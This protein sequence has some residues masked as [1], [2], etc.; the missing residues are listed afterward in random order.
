MPSST[1]A[2]SASSSTAT[3]RSTPCRRS[4]CRGRAAYGLVD[5]EKIFRPD[6]HRGPDIFDSRGIDRANGCTVV[7]RSDR[8]VAHILPLDDHAGLATFFAGF[9]T[10]RRRPA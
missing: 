4:S 1:C 10:D 6:L 7:V 9:M 8:H 3:S 5:D 2:P